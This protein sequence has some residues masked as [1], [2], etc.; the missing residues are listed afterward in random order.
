MFV[1]KKLKTGI[2]RDPNQA[3]GECSGKCV[4]VAR[5]GATWLVIGILIM[6]FPVTSLHP[7]CPT[8]GNSA[9]TS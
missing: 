1:V 5:R 9:C 4:V 8:L 6:T 7:E 3:G 2:Y